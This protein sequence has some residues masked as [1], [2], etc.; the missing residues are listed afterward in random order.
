[1]AGLGAGSRHSC[2]DGPLI[3]AV[4]HGHSARGRGALPGGPVTPES[5]FRPRRN[6][7]AE[8]EPVEGHLRHR[9]PWAGLPQQ[10]GG[11]RAA[12]RRGQRSGGRGPHCGARAG[13]QPAVI[14]AHPPPRHQGSEL[15]WGR[16]QPLEP[17]AG[18][19][20]LPC[21][22]EPDPW[23]AQ[24]EWEVASWDPR[25]GLWGLAARRGRASLGLKHSPRACGLW[26]CL[27]L[28]QVPGYLS[29]P[30][31][32]FKHEGSVS[33]PWSWRDGAQG[34]GFLRET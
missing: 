3:T 15:P 28:W 25:C 30:C 23:Q 20:T 33:G 8:E 13:V 14:A 7:L 11:G 10:P 6:W 21:G 22:R 24:E 5:W 4:L 12:L 9:L 18:G 31:S 26:A 19:V 2:P 17:E 27:A 34:P 29:F 1:M 16:S 32:P